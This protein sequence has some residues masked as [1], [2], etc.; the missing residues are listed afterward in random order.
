MANELREQYSELVLK[1]LRSELTLKD[2]VVFNNDF[3]GDPV[4]GAVKIPTR[5]DEVAA[6][7]YDRAAGLA[8]AERP[9]GLAQRTQRAGG[10]A[11]L[12]E[13][14]RRSP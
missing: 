12:P 10:A 7:D 13:P 3:D 11:P 9:K 4:A 2:G 14:Q 1:K 6:G 5:E 8:P